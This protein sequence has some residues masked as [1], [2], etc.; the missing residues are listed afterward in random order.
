MLS[1]GLARRCVGVVLMAGLSS[2]CSAFAKKKECKTLLDD[3]NRNGSAIKQIEKSNDPRKVAGSARS[4]AAIASQLASD[5]SGRAFRLSELKQFARDYAS[6]ANQAASGMNEMA[7]V[8]D[9]F[10]DL[11]DQ[12]DDA[13]STSPA[14]KFV[15]ATQKFADTCRARPS[16]GCVG[17]AKVIQG[18][19]KKGE[20][21][22]AYARGLDSASADMKRV[23]HEAGLNTVVDDLV[24]QTAELGK[25]FRG[26]ADATRKLKTT[27]AELDTTLAREKPLNASI[28]AF[29]QVR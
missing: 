18:L 20:D 14:K 28:N 16:A 23:P 2:G 8:M 29:C 3:V 6:F 4:T 10:A 13:S 17:I 21:M 26:I 12:V 25:V 27:Q 7:K 5:V 9:Q 15:S 24:R 22:D 19:P 1:S 11:K